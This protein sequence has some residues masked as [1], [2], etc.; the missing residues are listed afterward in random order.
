MKK[1]L[2]TGLLAIA[3]LT[4]GKAATIQLIR[5]GAGTGIMAQTSAGV[6]LSAGGYYIGVGTYAAPPV[7]TTPATLLTAAQAF[8]EAVALA[9]PT[10]G[11]TVGLIIGSGDTI[12]TAF[13]SAPFYLLIGNAA[14]RAL[15]TEFAILA[16]TPAGTFPSNVGPAGAFTYSIV[17]ITSIAPV[18]NAG[19]EIDSPAGT[20]DR[21]KLVSTLIP[22][23]S[24]ALLGAV[25]ALGLLRRRRN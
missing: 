5:S 10:S 16:L 15:S 12:N 2:L 22:E 25:S 7:V 14:T 4:A 20:S 11:G 21:I 8:Q 13:N 18:T 17:D 9:S 23:P 1:T 6:D 19:T 3:S 24:T